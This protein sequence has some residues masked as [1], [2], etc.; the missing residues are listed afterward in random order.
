MD[1]G[2]IER[3]DYYSPVL[4]R[5]CQMHVFTPRK[6]EVARGRGGWREFPVLYLLGGVG[7]SDSQWSSVGRAGVILQNLIEDGVAKPMIVVM[8]NGRIDEP[9]QV[10]PPGVDIGDELLA[11]SFPTSMRTTARKTT[12]STE[13][14]RGAVTWRLHRVAAWFY[15]P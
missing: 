12:A 3:V 15:P 1:Y 6:Y 14:S 4:K 10:N 7:E 2:R 5:I 9:G 11:R 8:T 13:R